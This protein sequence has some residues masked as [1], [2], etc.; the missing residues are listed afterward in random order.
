MVRWAEADE[1]AGLVPIELAADRL[2][3]Q[4]GIVFPPGTTMIEEVADPHAVLV[5]ERRPTGSRSSARSTGACISTSSPYVPSACA[6]ASA[7]GS[8]RR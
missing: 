2:F 8:S 6:R 3:E 5:E 4:V 1:L 7:G